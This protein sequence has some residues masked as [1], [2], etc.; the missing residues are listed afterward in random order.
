MDNPMPQ[1]GDVHPLVGSS[2][3]VSDAEE[4][5]LRNRSPSSEG[6]LDLE[7]DVRIL[8]V[9]SHAPL[10]GSIKARLG[11]EPRFSIVGIAQSPETAIATLAAQPT[12]LVLMDID[13][14]EDGQFKAA[15]AI[16]TVSPSVHIVFLGDDL[17]DAIIE[18]ALSVGERVFVLNQVTPGT[19]LTAIQVVLAVVSW[20]P[21]E[22]RSRIVV[23]ADG[24]RLSHH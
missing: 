5:S 24:L 3:T 16:R 4:S 21:E 7:E 15:R 10:M 14:A 17:Q 13:V 6:V 11:R 1:A 18:Q 20:F 9:G 8:L 23:D 2:V 12:D 19:I 22:V